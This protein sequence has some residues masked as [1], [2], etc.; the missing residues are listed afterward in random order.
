MKRY[1]V[2]MKYLIADIVEVEAH[3]KYE[4]IKKAEA[5]IGSADEEP[6]DSQVIRHFHP[7]AKRI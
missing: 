3:S 6:V 4:A 2:I 7:I 1:R 5:N